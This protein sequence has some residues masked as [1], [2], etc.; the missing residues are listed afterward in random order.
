MSILQKKQHIGQY[1][2]TFHIKDG[3]YAETYRVKDVS[4]KNFFIKLLDYSKVHRTQ[5]D[6]NGDVLEIVMSKQLK[7]PNT[8]TFH[9]C[10]E[11]VLDNKKFAYVVYDFISGETLAQKLAREQMLSVFDA[12]E[13]ILG[14]LEGVKFLHSLPRPIIHNEL[15]AQNVMLDMTENNVKI[16][17]FGY[18]RFLDQGNKSFLKS[19]LSPFYMA[20]ETFNG[21]FTQQSDLYSVGAMLYHLLFGLPPYFMDLSKYENDTEIADA[22]F[23]ERKRPLKILDCNKFELDEQLINVIEKALAFDVDNRFSSADEFIKA[24]KGDIIVEPI[25]RN[26]SQLKKSSENPDANIKKGTDI[27][28]KI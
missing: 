27:N 9:D 22:I 24:L 1:V 19:G 4:G 12:K 17:D 7:H 26:K 16:I 20:P 8:T 13:M 10:G 11:L 2:V 25:N 5:F 18:A 6:D 3:S 28:Q 21:V 23:T 15:T 14:V